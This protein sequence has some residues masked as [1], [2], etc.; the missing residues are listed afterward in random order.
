MITRPAGFRARLSRL[1]RDLGI[2]DDP[3]PV[4]GG[5]LAGVGGLLLASAFGVGE[6]AIAA[7]ATWEGYHLLRFGARPA[8]RDA[9]ASPPRA[10]KL[11]R[12][13]TLRRSA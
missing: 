4:I 11:R 1:G 7:A 10:R 2:D 5:A 3:W 9:H 6:I 12:I 13:D 8:G